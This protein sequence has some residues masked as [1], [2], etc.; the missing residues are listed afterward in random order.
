MSIVTDEY[1]NV[2]M[3]WVFSSVFFFFFFFFFFEGKFYFADSLMRFRP[4]YNEYE[5]YSVS[6]FI[7]SS[8]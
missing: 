3:H 6:S 2:C 4:R 8:C 5:V 7:V 1:C